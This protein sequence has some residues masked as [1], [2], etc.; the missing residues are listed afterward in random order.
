MEMLNYTVLTYAIYLSLSVR[1]TIWVGQTLHKNGRVFLVDAFRGNIEL[2]DSVNSLLL[3]GFYLI[4]VGFVSLALRA[5]A[6]PVNLESA[7]E[8][9][10]S[11]LGIVMLVLGAMHLFNVYVFSRMRTDA[12]AETATEKQPATL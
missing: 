12:I 4:N 5:N 2:A 7:M 10:S 11:K 3:V 1:L 8:L 6:K 9:L